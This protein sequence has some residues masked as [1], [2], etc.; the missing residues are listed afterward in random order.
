M[1]FG[2]ESG[3]IPEETEEVQN[4]VILQPD[5]SFYNGVYLRSYEPDYVKRAKSRGASNYY[6]DHLQLQPFEGNPE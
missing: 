1:T 5:K 2:G 3:L 6:K 4:R